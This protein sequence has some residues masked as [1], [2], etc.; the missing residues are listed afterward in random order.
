MRYL[1]FICGDIFLTSR[2]NDLTSQHKYLTS[3]GRNMPPLGH[4]P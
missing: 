1:A 4:L 2:Q 3:D